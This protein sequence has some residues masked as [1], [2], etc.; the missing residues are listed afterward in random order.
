MSEQAKLRP[1]PSSQ[2][3]EY[4]DEIIA[5]I[6]REVRFNQPREDTLEEESDYEDDDNS[7]N[8]ER[9]RPRAFSEAQTSIG[10]CSLSSH[11]NED[12]AGHKNGAAKHLGLFQHSMQPSRSQGDLRKSANHSHGL[13]KDGNL[14]Q[15]SRDIRGGLSR[16]ILKFLKV[17]GRRQGF[18]RNSSN[19]IAGTSNSDRKF[20]CC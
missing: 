7:S 20:Y 19:G 18:N 13:G 12:R 14:S 17:G 6:A 4:D 16:K 9:A 5:N 3:N 15:S 1:P 2:Q 11:S 10:S 8:G